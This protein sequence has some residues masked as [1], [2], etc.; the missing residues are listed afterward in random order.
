MCS[1]L[2]ISSLD[3]GAPGED[4]QTIE[5]SMEQA[6]DRVRQIVAGYKPNKGEE[7]LKLMRA[8]MVAI[9]GCKKYIE[10]NSAT[11]RGC[12]QRMVRELY[13][14]LAD[15]P[16]FRGLGA[17]KDSVHNLHTRKLAEDSIDVIY[18]QLRDLVKEQE[19]GKVEVI[20]D[21]V[22]THPV[23]GE[24][25]T[26]LSKP[27]PKTAYVLLFHKGKDDTLE[28]ITNRANDGRIFTRLRP[29]E[30]KDD[31]HV[32][33]LYRGKRAVDGAAVIAEQELI[34]V[35][36]TVPAPSENQDQL[37]ALL[38]VSSEAAS[39]PAREFIEANVVLR[40][41]HALARHR[42][43]P[44]ES[45][46]LLF[47]EDRG[48]DS[49]DAANAHETDAVDDTAEVSQEQASI[50]DSGAQPDGGESTELEND[51]ADDSIAQPHV[52]EAVEEPETEAELELVQ[53][54][55]GET[56]SDETK[57][58]ST[59]QYEEQIA[60]RATAP[61][62]NAT[63]SQ[64]PLKIL[65]K[66]SQDGKVISRFWPSDFAQRY[67]LFEIYKDKPPILGAAVIKE[68]ELLH[69]FGAVP[70]PTGDQS[71]LDALRQVSWAAVEKPHV[72]FIEQ[73]EVFKGLHDLA[74]GS[75]A[76][77]PVDVVLF[78]VAA[79]G[80]LEAMSIGGQGGRPQVR[81]SLAQFQNAK[82][83]HDRFGKR[84]IVGASVISQSEAPPERENRF[85]QKREGGD[86]DRDNRRR[87][88]QQ[89][90]PKPVVLAAFGRTPLKVNIIA[91]PE[92]LSRLG[93]ELD[94]PMP[95]RSSRPQQHSRPPRRQ[96]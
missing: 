71:Q 13:E 46:I 55:A 6:V 79:N 77:K 59:E 89:A 72:E 21:W 68:N 42:N 1:L 57:T 82:L 84:N 20:R 27:L 26:V 8:L 53:E 81:L 61:V 67:K 28:L 95:P 80:R 5:M 10:E 24:L 56:D 38:N 11:D 15:L 40:E 51:K 36:G 33:K 63:Q 64:V 83:V 32:H 76:S 69:V 75:M 2:F 35:M 87:E 12:A 88:P 3:S 25:K 22:K 90:S 54:V 31:L 96:K 17:E 49:G 48:D 52:P 85:H 86:R 23:F 34:A 66:N 94:A 70:Q 50:D 45:Y 18:D 60:D 41:L 93:I 62:C 29:Q 7:Q 19:Q 43:F 91:T 74:T 9:G 14:V 30:F 16:T 39:R 44:K 65:V 37:K 4:M 73:H 58:R 78:T 47:G 92:T